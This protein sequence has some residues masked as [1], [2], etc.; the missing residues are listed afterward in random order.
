[1][2]LVAKFQIHILR[3]SDST[4]ACG[5]ALEGHNNLASQGCKTIGVKSI[6]NGNEGCLGGFAIY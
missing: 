5:P 4:G 2:S 1:M 6:V 3:D